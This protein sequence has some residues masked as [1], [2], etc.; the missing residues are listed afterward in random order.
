MPFVGGNMVKGFRVLV[1]ESSFLREY[2]HI[3]SKN[4]QDKLSTGGSCEAFT[5]NSGT[6][7]KYIYIYYNICKFKPQYHLYLGCGPYIL[8]AMSFGFLFFLFLF[9]FFKSSYLYI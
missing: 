8:F 9:F 3:L 1:L 7:K 4:V 2:M 5:S 6:A